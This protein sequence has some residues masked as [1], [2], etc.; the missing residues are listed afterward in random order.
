MRGKSEN[1]VLPRPNA[2]SPTA[3]PEMANLDGPGHGIRSTQLR[4]HPAIHIERGYG[5]LNWTRGK[6]KFRETLTHRLRI[7]QTR[8]WGTIL[9][10]VQAEFPGSWL[11]L[12][13]P[14]QHFRLADA[15]PYTI[16]GTT[17]RRNELQ[18]LIDVGL[19]VSD[20]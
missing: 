6:L 13:R 3:S 17:T 12:L 5:R 7:W 19:S 8:R 15:L 4:A 9:S 1:F 2:K 10:L 16:L 20:K 14:H 18:P 11:S